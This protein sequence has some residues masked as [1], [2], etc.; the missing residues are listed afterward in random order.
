MK[1][2]IAFEI[3]KKKNMGKKA[4]LSIIHQLDTKGFCV[5]EIYGY[6]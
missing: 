2:S 6:D 5:R 1:G 4:A 3:L